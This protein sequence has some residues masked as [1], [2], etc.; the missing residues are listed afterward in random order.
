MFGFAFEDTR[1]VRFAHW[2]AQNSLQLIIIIGSSLVR[3]TMMEVIEMMMLTTMM[4]TTTMMMM[5]TITMMMMMRSYLSDRSTAFFRL[6]NPLPCCHQLM[7]IKM[8]CHHT[9]VH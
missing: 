1:Y 4:M 7:M 3:V 2:Q 8:K 9:R 5:M 6:L